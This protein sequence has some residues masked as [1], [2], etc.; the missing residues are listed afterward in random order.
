VIDIVKAA[1][2]KLIFRKKDG[3]EGTDW[4]AML[5]GIWSRLPRVTGIDIVLPDGTLLPGGSAKSRIVLKEWRAVLAF[6]T[7]DQPGLFECYLSG[8]LDLESLE[9]DAARALLHT[10]KVLDDQWVDHRWATAALYSSRHFW[11]QNT[12]FRR[13]AL[14][15]HYSVPAPFWLS[16]MS[17]EYPIYSHYIFQENETY[18]AWETACQRKLEFALRACRL[19]PGDRVLNIGEGWGGFLTYAGRRGIRVTGITLND[20]SY[21][22]CTEK[23]AAESLQG[24]CEVI[25]GDYYHYRANQPFDAITNMGVTEH[26]TDYD[27]LMSKYASMLRPG[28]YAY[29]DFVGTTRDTPFRSVIQKEVYP[30]ATPVN[31]RQLIAAVQRNG[32]LDL[33][34]AYDDRSSYD[35]TCEAW[36]RNVEAQRDFIVKNFGERRY[37]W[38]WSYLWMCVYG[39][40][41][42]RNGVTGT[43]VVIRRR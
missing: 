21:Q 39:F 28:G 37:R 11:Q 12:P 15:V 9:G 10:L 19:Q 3:G 41:T 31:L 30:G 6:M 1:T 23:L 13:A 42:F 27:A 32:H 25:K 26:L 33:V 4:R 17:R 8:Q 5:S 7:A 14:R 38:I 18:E 34:E 2:E 29:S 22:A 43:R 40:R 20:E 24:Q 16:F 35:K 36:A